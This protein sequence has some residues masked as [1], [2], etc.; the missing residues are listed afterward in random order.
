[1]R[2]NY[3]PGS[4]LDPLRAELLGVWGVGPETADV[5]LLYAFGRPVFVIDAYTR[6]ILERTG[7]ISAAR[8]LSYDRLQ[9]TVES[10]LPADASLFNEY[11]A[12]LV[13]HGK[14][15]CAPDPRCASC[16]VARACAYPD[17]NS[18]AG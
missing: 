17:A 11:H 16:P 1:M 18:R 5:I 12:L 2:V 15:Y 3:K 9:A 13:A 8:R 10:G 6:R 4:Q 7:T 14:A